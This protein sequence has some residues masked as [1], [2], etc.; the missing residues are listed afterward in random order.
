MVYTHTQEYYSA[1][2]KNE[3]V[4]FSATWVDLEIIVLSEI[5]QRQKDNH[6]VVSLILGLLKNDT[7]EII[8]KTEIDPQT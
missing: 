3:T 5:S 2:E 4:P 7:K 1:T 8:Y 6:H